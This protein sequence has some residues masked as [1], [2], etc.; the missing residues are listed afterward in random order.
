MAVRREA[1]K[2]R[3]KAADGVAMLATPEGRVE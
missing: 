1:M 2:Y 3:V